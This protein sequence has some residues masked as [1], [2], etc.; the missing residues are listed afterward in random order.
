MKDLYKAIS[1]CDVFSIEVKFFLH[2]NNSRSRNIVGGLI[3]IISFLSI[4][5]IMIYF[6]NNFVGRK[7]PTLM[8][9]QTYTKNNTIHNIDQV[10]FLFRL[11]DNF[12]N[13]YDDPQSLYELVF[14][15]FIKSKNPIT[16]TTTQTYE[17]METESCNLDKHFGN[18]RYLFVNI[19]DLDTYFCPKWTSANY[20]LFGQYGDNDDYS[21]LLWLIRSCRNGTER[22]EPIVCRD[23]D[24]IKEKLSI[25][26]VEYLTVDNIVNSISNNPKD[27]TIKSDRFPISNTIFKRIYSRYQNI[28]FNDDRGYVFEDIQK[29]SF[30]QFQSYKEEIDLRDPELIQELPGAFW[31]FSL[32]H[33]DTTIT[34]YRG[35]SK[36]QNFLADV[37]GVIKGITSI[38]LILTYF[39]SEKYF[40]QDLI[41]QNSKMYDIITDNIYSQNTLLKKKLDHFNQIFLNER[42]NLENENQ[43]E[44]SNTKRLNS[45]QHIKNKSSKNIEIMKEFN[46]NTQRSNNHLNVKNIKSGNL[47]Q[48][49]IDTPNTR[50]ENNLNKSFE[51]EFNDSLPSISHNKNINLLQKLSLLKKRKTVKLSLKEVLFPFFCSPHSIHKLRYQVGFGE[52]VNQL[53]V[54]NL[55]NQIYQF[56]ILKKL[57][58]DDDQEEVFNYLFSNPLKTKAP[59]KEI[60]NSCRELLKKENNSI[61]D[62][63]LIQQIKLRVSNIEN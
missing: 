31:W 51:D 36:L 22:S 15:I 38:G 45:Y 2:K 37:G 46:L 14:S 18:Y 53:N 42:N 11:S 62:Y 54:P 30:F 48:T 13:L 60:L 23:P 52:L 32:S 16:N 61:I 26:Y 20:T 33:T 9:N 5:G 29:T 8:S 1:Y 35:Y 39:I 58:L 3:S 43:V 55:L 7:N 6:F 59:D 34:Y 28:V 63:K 21:F 40:Y 27:T 4:A 24:E 10:P 41:N 57:I 50:K 25:T 12:R 49:N 47:H 19:T 44:Y 17:K 56:R